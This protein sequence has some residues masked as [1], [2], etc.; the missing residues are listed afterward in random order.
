M[1]HNKE[2][3]SKRDEKLD[4]KSQAMEEL[5]AE[6]EKK[7]NKT[8]RCDFTSLCRDCWQFSHFRKL[9]FHLFGKQRNCWPSA[10]P[11]RPARF[12]PTT[13]RKRRKTM[14]SHQSKVIGVR[15]HHRMMKTSEFCSASS[16]S[17]DQ[18]TSLS[19]RFKVTSWLPPTEKKKLH[20][21]RSLFLYQTSSTGSGCP[22][23]SWSAGATCP[24][25][26]RPWLAALWG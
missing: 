25:L 18:K 10:S 5:K 19:S 12:T 6:R 22:D 23:T 15:V 8:G 14:T 21:S 7:K 20:R 1:S 16:V 2:R 17:Q 9:T 3:R 11:W 4:K 26:L 13:R 24:S